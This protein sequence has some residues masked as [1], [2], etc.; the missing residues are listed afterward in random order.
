MIH[1][2]LTGLALSFL[3]MPEV[4]PTKSNWKG[5][6]AVA[7]LMVLQPMFFLFGQL[8]RVLPLLRKIPDWLGF[9]VLIASIPVWSYFFGWVFIR[10]KDWLNH[11][12]VL[13]RKVF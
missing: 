1:L 12:P 13:G 9:I 6:F 3:V 11:F 4:G 8:P 10:L 7:S 5:V 2:F